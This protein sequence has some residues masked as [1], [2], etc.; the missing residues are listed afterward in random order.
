MLR[1]FPC[2]LPLVFVSFADVAACEGRRASSIGLPDTRMWS[3]EREG[4]PVSRGSDRRED[5]GAFHMASLLGE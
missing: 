3:W 2:P 1:L 5:S 4:F